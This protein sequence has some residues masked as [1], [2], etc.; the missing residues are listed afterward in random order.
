MKNSNAF[1]YL[2]Y[3]GPVVS[4]TDRYINSVVQ[5]YVMNTA[6]NI[7]LN[8]KTAEYFCVHYGGVCSWLKKNFNF[9]NAK[10]YEQTA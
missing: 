6:A 9:I 5:Y 1:F 2:S 8:V 10:K 7:M 4:H 3:E